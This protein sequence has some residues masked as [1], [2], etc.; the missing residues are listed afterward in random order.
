MNK[1]TSED[2]EFSTWYK[3]KIL[4]PIIVV[5]AIIGFGYRAIGNLSVGISKPHNV[6]TF[7]DDIIP[8]NLW[9]LI[10]YLL[11]SLFPYASL[12][13][14]FNKKIHIVELVSLYVSHILLLVSCY[15]IYVIFPTSAESIMIKCSAQDITQ[16]GFLKSSLCKVYSTS[17]PY[18]AFPSYHVT[19]MVF[20]S[21]FLWYKWRKLF[22]LS[23]PIAISASVATVFIKFHFFVDILGGIVMG[24]FGYYCIYQRL[25]LKYFKNHS[26]FS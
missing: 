1:D 5:F 18:N 16:Y 19:A 8:L 26:I 21:I 2:K 10:P 14:A 7:V 11:W 6:K 4:I 15:V 9:F 25:V 23:L 13:L 17:V 12:V 22:W 3:V 24:Y 20:I